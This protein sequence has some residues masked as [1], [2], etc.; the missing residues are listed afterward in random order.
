MRV[1]SPCL[2]PVIAWMTL[3]AMLLLPLNTGRAVF[4]QDEPLKVGIPALREFVEK[5][6][7]TYAWEVVRQAGGNPATVFT[8]KLTS[9]TWRTTEDVNRPL[10]EHWLV[11][12]KPEQVSSEK[13]FIM[14]GGGSND[15]GPP[16]R[17]DA[18]LLA[19]AE[20]T[21]SVVA[22]LRMI[23][24]QAL[25]F[26]QDGVPRKEDD[27]IGYCWDQFIK[28]GDA[29]WL[30]RLPMVKSVSRAM[31]CITELLAS[32]QGG[33]LPIKSFV[34][35]G[36]S[37][38]GWTTW[39]TPVAD[40]R[41]EA[42]VPIVIDVLNVG[43]SMEHHA[44]VYG[45]WA[46]AIGNYYQHGIMQRWGHP[47]LEELYRVVDPYYHLE[48]LQLPKFIVNAAGD[49]FFCPD[50]SK[51]Y[52][53]ELKGE[54]LIRY[55]PNADH[56]LRN[57]DALES[58]LA[59]YQRILR[60]EARP[61]YD[62]SF[63]PDGSIRVTTP[64]RPTSVRLW[65]AEN[66]DSRDFRLMTIGPGFQSQPLEADEEG[67]YVGRVEIPE[68]GWKA[69]FVELTYETPGSLPLK[70]TTAVRVVPDVLPHAGVDPREVPYEL[71]KD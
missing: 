47:R 66:P 34:V 60:G 62:W 23:P 12:V 10:W 8:V 25:E 22:E 68:Q 31:D 9:Q 71:E 53:D 36:A 56:S 69:Y 37:K 2:A 49:Q 15:S 5:D 11:V 70:V 18:G 52:W 7:P 59:F 44:Q 26:H 17:P 48:S 41:V 43:P 50:S 3:I 33:E 14:I 27:L 55:V 35:A 40:S 28:T 39:M 51:F 24:N 1:N 32:D 46:A 29:T 65:H 54:K 38:R 16:E 13:A 30:P 4:G 63:E 19:I 58:I 6:D 42:I 20:A 64:D 45:F 57:S 67:V 21:E 61:R